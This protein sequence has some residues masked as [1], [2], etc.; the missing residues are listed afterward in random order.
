[1]NVRLRIGDEERPLEPNP[2]IVGATPAAHWDLGLH[3]GPDRHAQFEV[4]AD[5][6]LWIRN[7]EPLPGT[8]TRVNG[9]VIADS[10]R[11][12]NADLIELGPFP[13]WCR[14]GATEPFNLTVLIE[15]LDAQHRVPEQVRRSPLLLSQR[16]DS[17]LLRATADTPA[18]PGSVVLTPNDAE[19]LEGLTLVAGDL[20]IHGINGPAVLRAERL[21]RVA[22]D[23]RITSCAEVRR[24]ELPGLADVGGDVV[25]D[26]LPDLEELAMPGLV[27]ARSI[28]VRGTTWLTSL[29]WPA[30]VEVDEGVTVAEN[31][32]L[33]HVALP[34][35]ERAARVRLRFNQVLSATA[36]DV[37]R[38]DLRLRVPQADLQVVHN[39][40]TDFAT[41]VKRRLQGYGIPASVASGAFERFVRIAPELIEVHERMLQEADFDGDR[42]AAIER[43][44]R[45][46]ALAQA[47][48]DEREDE[49]GRALQYLIDPSPSPQDVHWLSRLD[50]AR[51]GGPI[52]ADAAR[53]WMAELSA[54]WE[55]V[56]PDD[57]PELIRRWRSRGARTLMARRLAE[58]GLYALAARTATR[59]ADAKLAFWLWE[60]V[61]D[62]ETEQWRPDERLEVETAA[63]CLGRLLSAGSLRD[64]GRAFIQ[65]AE[66]AVDR[67][68]PART[69][70]IERGGRVTPV[71]RAAAAWLTEDIVEL[72][73]RAPA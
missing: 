23:L 4:H 37:L 72:E 68:R 19:R 15:G 33:C 44:R 55:R 40:H 43:L 10:R 38:Q 69:V 41:A 60:A 25:L 28:T 14:P 63:H 45:L 50:E 71:A 42:A 34:T 61:L 3:T 36:V 57:F 27:A 73:S 21:T 70:E 5:L 54:T 62:L 18:R 12:G 16:P 29:A 11:I 56:H 65:L 52:E 67:E 2:L 20:R 6:S 24:I 31:R 30:L 64:A 47:Q 48:N 39:G 26:A 7:L 8:F 17:F 46:L 1:M 53:L 49:Y 59:S 51:T 22:G 35:L 13:P 66:A 58:A 9:V 32:L